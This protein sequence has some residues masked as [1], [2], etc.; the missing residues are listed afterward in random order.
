MIMYMYTNVGGSKSFPFPKRSFGSKGETRSIYYLCSNKLRMI[1]DALETLHITKKVPYVCQFPTTATLAFGWESS[2][3][4]TRAPIRVRAARSAGKT[5]S[6]SLSLEVSDSW[7][8]GS[9][10]Y[11]SRPKGSPS[12]ASTSE[13]LIILETSDVTRSLT[14]IYHG[15]HYFQL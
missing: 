8:V 15:A 14:L 9:K 1:C 5:L 6:L 4:G 7:L 12:V 3:L 10:R 11:G 13:S 2:A